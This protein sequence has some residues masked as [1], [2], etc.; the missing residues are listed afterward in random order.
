MT[1]SA[2]MNAWFRNPKPKLAAVLVFGLLIVVI[3]FSDNSSEQ[4]TSRGKDGCYET[5]LAMKSLEG[6]NATTPF[7]VTNQVRVNRIREYCANHEFEVT[8]SFPKYE[9]LEEVMLTWIWLTSSQ[10]QL[11]YCATPK[12]GSTTWKS[13]IM[14][15]MR[16]TWN[17]DTHL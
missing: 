3:K 14:E 6:S 8:S 11:Y 12:C 9:R 13:F 4:I 10:H 5:L 17:V 7:G 2:A 15:D 16:L 1:N